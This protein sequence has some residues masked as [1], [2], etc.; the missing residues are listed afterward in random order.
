MRLGWRYKA[1]PKKQRFGKTRL[2]AELPLL[3]SRTRPGIF[4]LA[5]A[6]LQIERVGHAFEIQTANLRDVLAGAAGMLVA[7]KHGVSLGLIGSE[8]VELGGG[9]LAGQ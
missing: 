2:P 6:A 9:T 7:L 8:A 1:W 4:V 3:D 5:N